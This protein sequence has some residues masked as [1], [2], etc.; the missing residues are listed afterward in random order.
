MSE[1][2]FALLNQPAFVLFAT[3][4]SYAECFG[5]MTGIICVW[6]TARRNILN[7]P[8]GIANA[9]LL[10]LLFLDARLFADAG[11]QIMFIALGVRGWWQWSRH[12]ELPPL[13]VTS[14]DLSSIVRHVAAGVAMTALLFGILAYAKGSVPLFD[15]LITA[16]SVV[17]QWLLNR[18]VIQNW[19]WWIAVDVISIPVYIHKDLY[20]IALLY[21]VFLAIC[22]HGLMSWRAEWRRTGVVSGDAEGVPAT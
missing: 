3:P 6:L 15:A 16:M 14:A 18:K 17:A 20:L 19:Y 8:F 5:F 11:L 13:P 4:L 1:E 2:F 12:G 22:V 21:G 7:F 9:A 10:L